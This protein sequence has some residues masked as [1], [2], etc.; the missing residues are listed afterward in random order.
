MLAK[1]RVA[2]SDGV[3]LS[4]AADTEGADAMTDTHGGV[5]G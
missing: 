4:T 5:C 2:E 1:A 3:R